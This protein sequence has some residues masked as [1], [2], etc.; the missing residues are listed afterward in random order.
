ME[1]Q[2]YEHITV[3]LEKGLNEKSFGI[4]ISGGSDSAVI[5]GGDPSI[6]V[7]DVIPGSPADSLVKY[8]LIR[9]SVGDIIIAING[10]NVEN[11][12]HE[13][14]VDMLRSLKKCVYLV[15]FIS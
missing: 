9:I 10:E 5:R 3:M 6:V 15:S 11:V 7:S 12:E 1:G 14:A 8:G 2:K 13:I 4:A